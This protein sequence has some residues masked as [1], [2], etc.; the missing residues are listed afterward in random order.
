MNWPPLATIILTFPIW[1]VVEG[2]LA[3]VYNSN[4][5]ANLKS[6]FKF[7]FF[8]VLVLSFA[9]PDKKAVSCI[10]IPVYR[11]RGPYSGFFADFLSSLVVNSDKV[12]IVGDFNIHMDSEGDPLRSAFLS[13][14]ESISPHIPITIWTLLLQ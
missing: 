13:I 10:L 14:I 8:E 1:R 2:V 6:G 12:V 9:H 11:P 5:H 3:A 4:L 7:N